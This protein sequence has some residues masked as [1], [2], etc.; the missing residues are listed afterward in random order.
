MADQLLYEQSAFVF[1]DNIAIP[2]DKS[3]Y[4]FDDVITR[5]NLVYSMGTMKRQANAIG[6]FLLH[7][8]D[9]R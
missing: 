6:G 1:D 9:G 7:F 4:R 2:E 5:H 3:S 8:R